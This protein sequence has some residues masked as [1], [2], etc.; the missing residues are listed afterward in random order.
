MPGTPR[1]A[2]CRLS[3]GDAKEIL[4]VISKLVDGLP[5]VRKG[6]ML[7]FLAKSAQ[8]LRS[9]STRKLF[10]RAHIDDS[11]VKVRF[12]LGHVSREKPAN[13]PDAVSAQGHDA[14]RNMSTNERERLLL[15]LGLGHV[16]RPNPF[17]QPGIPMMRLIPLVHVS[18]S[19]YVLVNREHRTLG[20]D[21]EFL[22]GNDGGDLD[23]HVALGIEA[24]HLEIHPHE[25]A[26][27]LG[28]RH[29]RNLHP[30]V[31]S[32]VGCSIEELRKRTK[33]PVGYDTIGS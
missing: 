14:G 30:K 19:F 10:D 6:E 25:V 32:L 1:L 28:M 20:N 3:A 31:C 23:D 15:G 13:L 5:D 27:V 22:V 21:H 8:E 26:V 11:I 18:Q 29:V 24:G 2:R 33:R 4:A 7:S 9:P 16:A 17:H 12:Q